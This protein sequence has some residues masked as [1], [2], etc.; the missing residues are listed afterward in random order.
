[1]GLPSQTTR[2]LS[3]Q[4]LLEELMLESVGVANVYFQP[5]ENVKMRYPAIVYNRDYG[6]SEFAGNLPYRHTRR[7]AVTVIDSDPDSEL[8]IRI[9]S[10]PMSTFSRSFRVDNLNHDIYMLYY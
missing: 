1:M 2:R 7:Y 6:L 3:L 4:S 9:A 8:P 10:L 5:P